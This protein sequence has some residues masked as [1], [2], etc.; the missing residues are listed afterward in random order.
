MTLSR[1]PSNRRGVAR[2]IEPALLASAARMAQRRQHRVS[3]GQDGRSER[4]GE[5]ARATPGHD[6]PMP[7]FAA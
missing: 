1:F 3:E 4:P 5:T 2:A 6:L 7:V